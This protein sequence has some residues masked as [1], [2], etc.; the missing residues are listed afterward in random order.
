MVIVP[1]LNI[2]VV[3][4]QSYNENDLMLLQKKVHQWANELQIKCHDI[5]EPNCNTFF[6]Y[7]I[8]IIDLNEVE[9]LKELPFQKKVVVVSVEELRPT[10]RHHFYERYPGYDLI[11][12]RGQKSYRWALR[13]VRY[14]LD[15]PILKIQYGNHLDQYGELMGVSPG[16]TFP[17]VVMIHGGFW[18]YSYER[19]L[20]YRMINY[21]IKQGIVVWNIEYRRIVKSHYSFGSIEEDIIS[22]INHL[23]TIQS[24]LKIDIESISIIGHSAGGYLAM[25][26][27]KVIN[28]QGIRIKNVIS[29][30]GILDLKIANELA[31]GNNALKEYFNTEISAEIIKLYS[32]HENMPNTNMMI[33]H[34][35]KDI[36]VPI[37]IS[38][39]FVKIAKK[40][41]QKISYIKLKDKDHM[42][43]TKPYFSFWNKIIKMI[44]NNKND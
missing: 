1:F 41:K 10:I 9:K 3:Y 34:G 15:I 18:K 14:T 33:V 2:D 19:D 23:K 8:L 7:D 16:L 42:D 38:D 17:I 26:A 37:I 24:F 28:K 39:S 12:G 29:L 27:A 5:Y 43:L 21:L 4:H 20:N 32:P 40:Q 36:T 6:T 30:A 44:K 13:Y 35:N 25:R 11:H 22:A 31:I